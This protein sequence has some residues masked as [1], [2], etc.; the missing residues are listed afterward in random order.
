MACVDGG[1]TVWD[2]Y[3]GTSLQARFFVCFFYRVVPSFLRLVDPSRFQARTTVPSTAWPGT[4]NRAGRTCCWRPA[5]TRRRPFGTR[6]PAEVVNSFSFLFL[7]FFFLNSPFI[8][9]EMSSVAYSK[10]KLMKILHGIES[11]EVQ[12]HLLMHWDS[13]FLF[14][15]K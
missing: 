12:S 13:L 5:T 1:L 7:L 3:G 9:M 14:I 15:F 2:Q 4:R 8:S 11:I 6:R 10:T